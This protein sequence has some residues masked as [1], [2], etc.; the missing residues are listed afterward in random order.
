MIKHSALPQNMY[1]DCGQFIAVYLREILVS[2][3]R[4]WR[5]KTP[6]HVEAM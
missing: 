2:A 3:H 6:K 1:A 4:I 5:E